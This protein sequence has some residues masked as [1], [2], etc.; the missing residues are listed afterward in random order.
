MEK[1]KQNKTVPPL[2]GTRVQL[3]MFAY[4]FLII[5]AGSFPPLYK[6]HPGPFLAT[7]FGRRWPALKAL[8]D[9]SILL[10]LSGRR[11]FVKQVNKYLYRG[12][13]QPLSPKDTWKTSIYFLSLNQF[14][15]EALNSQW[16]KW[17]ERMFLLVWNLPTHLR[18]PADAVPLFRL[19]VWVH[20]HNLTFCK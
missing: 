19:H 5:L 20:I 3:Q 4:Y 11:V 7:I 1:T 12:M 18:S 16:Q 8:N 10:D 6:I 13:P 2:Q 15:V 17:F 9:W 14:N